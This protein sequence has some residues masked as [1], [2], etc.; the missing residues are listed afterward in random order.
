MRSAGSWRALIDGEWPDALLRDVMQPRAEHNSS[1]ILDDLPGV[2]E[3]TAD[4]LV[5][6][7]LLY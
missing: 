3:N 5:F 6:L 1:F 7:N 4:C 2:N